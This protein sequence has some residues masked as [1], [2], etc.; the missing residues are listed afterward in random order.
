MEQSATE[1]S[2]HSPGIPFR[3]CGP[4][5]SKRASDPTTMSF[6]GLDARMSPGAASPWIGAATCRYR[7]ASRPLARP[8]PSRARG[9][10]SRPRARPWRSTT[11]RLP[12]SPRFRTPAPR[13][14]IPSRRAMG[15]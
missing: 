13:A 7:D 12:A 1:E 15:G 14:R 3:A 11:T 10:A 8:G 2:R 6:P 9:R 5:F 4:R